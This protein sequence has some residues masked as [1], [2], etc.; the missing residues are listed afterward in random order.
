MSKIKDAIIDGKYEPNEYKFDAENHIHTYL[1][2]PL[3]GTS[4]VVG[5]ISK[6]LT[7]WASGLAV[8]EFGWT[9]KGNDKVGWTPRELRLKIARDTLEEIRMMTDDQY[10]TLLD[11]A[12]S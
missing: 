9:N 8:K 2:K 7:W 1:D 3:L 10:L 4:T 6:P 5:I 11:K 12:Y